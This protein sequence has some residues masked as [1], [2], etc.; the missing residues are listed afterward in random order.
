MGETGRNERRGRGGGEAGR[1]YGG[2]KRVGKGRRDE[3]VER[4]RRGK[5]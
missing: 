1:K 3:V 4:W 2:G 5:R